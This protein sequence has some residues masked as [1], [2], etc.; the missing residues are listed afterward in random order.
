ML[1]RWPRQ[2]GLDTDMPFI[3]L[4]SCLHPTIALL[5]GCWISEGKPGYAY[6]GSPSSLAQF[7]LCTP[8]STLTL[9]VLTQVPPHD[10]QTFCSPNLAHI[11]ECSS[12]SSFP[13]LLLPLS[14]FTLKS[15]QALSHEI[16]TCG[17]VLKWWVDFWF[18][19]NRTSA[20]DKILASDR[21]FGDI[22]LLGGGRTTPE[23]I[24]MVD[25]FTMAFWVSVEMASSSPVY[26]MLALLGR[27]VL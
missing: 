21:L 23:D 19:W 12:L 10:L 2:V 25:W 24:L 16:I 27:G 3:T 5:A 20:S 7:L 8:G 26:P 11:L 14:W 13:L 9:W 15:P 18:V 17:D 4:K 6:H 1:P 22:H